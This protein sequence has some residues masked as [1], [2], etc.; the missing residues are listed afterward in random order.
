M[1][2]RAKV[3]T[4]DLFLTT[5]GVATRLAM[6]EL[7]SAKIDP[8]PLLARAGISLL[9]LGEEPKRVGAESQIRF[10]EIAADALGD[11]ALGLHLA[12]HFDL[13]ECGMLYYVLA[14][15]QNLGEAIRNLARYLA[16]SNESLRVDV[17]EKANNTVLTIKYKIPRHID[18][19]FVEYGYAVVLRAFR[20]LTGR[21]LC[22]KAVTFI[23][24]RSS[25]KTEFNRFFACPLTFGAAV[26]TMVFPTELLATPILTSDKYLLEVLKSACEEVLAKRGKISGS[27]RA[28]VENEL[29]PLLPHGKAQVEIVA[30]NLGMSERTL[31]RRLS[32]EGTSFA[33]ILNDLRRDL[34]ERYLK[35]PALS[36]NQIAW[37]LG[38]SMVTSLNHAFRRWTGT[39]PKSM[40]M[41]IG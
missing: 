25:N 19:L 27:L 16:V 41:T 22:P 34:S 37:L 7:K 28:M 30:G 36:L 11:T 33:I 9:K 14:A 20:E 26:D 3:S 29:V 35:D 2:R 39:S 23:H 32:E 24:G 17:S 12:Q 18:Q 4:G 8:R 40:S 6:R 13:R 31:A 1:V 38:Y 10:L 15:S 5:D 21:R